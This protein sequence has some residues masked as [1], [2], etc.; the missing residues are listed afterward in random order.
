V[1]PVD[2]YLENQQAIDRAIGF[3]CRRHHLPHEDAREFSQDVSAHLLEDDRA[4]LRA[5]DRRSSVQTFLIAVVIHLYQDWRNAKWGKWRPSAEARRTGEVAVLLETC[6]VR[7]KLAMDQAVET[8]RTNH[9]VTESREV[10]EQMA[11]RFP[12]RPGRT[13]VSEEVLA[14]RAATTNGA[15]AGLDAERARRTAGRAGGA[16]DAALKILPGEDQL[17]LRMRYHD[18]RTVAEIARTLKLDQKPLYGRI[19]R[20]RVGLRRTLESSGIEAQDMRDVLEHRG[21]DAP[22]PAI[23]TEPVHGVRPFK[24][25]SAPAARR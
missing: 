23:P 17:I 5:F 19:E 24:R 18:G 9:G 20:L 10:L 1:A 11:A 13:F 22:E 2:P 12:S 16:L 3:V 8:L 25:R 14:E 21:F 7:D 6:L 15:E 4:V